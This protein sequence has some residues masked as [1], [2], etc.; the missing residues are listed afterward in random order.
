M[1]TLIDGGT[2]KDDIYAIIAK[3]NGGK[4]NPTSIDSVEVCTKITAEIK[5]KY[6]EN[7]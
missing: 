1:G 3:N 2:N 7:K 4:K 6:K 5:K